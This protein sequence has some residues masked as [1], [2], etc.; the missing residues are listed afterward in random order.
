MKHI[1]LR[2]WVM[3]L[4]I[5]GSWKKWF[6]TLSWG[7]L[8]MRQR[9]V[10]WHF[11]HAT[12]NLGAAPRPPQ[13]VGLTPSNRK[14][15]LHILGKVRG[16]LNLVCDGP[17]ELPECSAGSRKCYKWAGHIGTERREGPVRLLSVK[18]ADKSIPLHLHNHVHALYRNPY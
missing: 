1:K 4:L 3:T 2:D 18:V 8:A 6:W 13:F 10:C 14:F 12:R 16:Q 7:R 9:T 15:A 17:A 11:I 5:Q